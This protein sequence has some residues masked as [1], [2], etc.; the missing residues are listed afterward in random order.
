MSNPRQ[1]PIIL[2]VATL[3]AI[4]VVAIAGYRIARNAELTPE[5]VRA[6]AESVDLSRLS[7]DERAAAIRKLAAM[8][9][10]LS[11]EDR[12]T[13]RLDR[14]AYKWFEKMTEAE[15]GA[16]LEATMPTGF[17]Q[18][19]AA[20]E[21]MPSDKRQRV[22][23]QAVRRMRSAREKLAS[24]GQMPPAGT[25]SVVLSAELQDKVTQIGLKSFYS[26]SSAQTKAEVAPLLE[27]MQHVLESGR[28]LREPGQ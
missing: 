6:Y 5:K 17:K 8:L 16:F 22:V 20:F 25:N 13:L 19:I 14:T 11:L 12:H 4:W 3:A 26:Q 1:R 10:A 7:A 2:A 9:N 27:E 18:M 28:M 15:K 23:D 21:E 24:E